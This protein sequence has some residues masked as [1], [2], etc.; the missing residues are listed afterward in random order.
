MLCDDAYHHSCHTP[1]IPSKAST[2]WKCCHCSDKYH[3]DKPEKASSKNKEHKELKEPLLTIIPPRPDTPTNPSNQ[4]PVLSPQVSPSR[5][6]IDQ[7]DEDLVT[8]ETIDP[9]IPDASDWTTEQVYQYF[10]RLFGPKEA[11]VFRV[12]VRPK[13]F[14]YF[15]HANNN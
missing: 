14:L 8:R 6:L 3:S 4:P 7:I 2:K 1:K 9:N 5:S 11:E 13:S 10:A 15:F 12:Q